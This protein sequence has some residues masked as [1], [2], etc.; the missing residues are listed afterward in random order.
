M[1]RG[2]LNPITKE[3][4]CSYNN[5][6]CN[7][8]Y[9][10]LYKNKKRN[11]IDKNNIIAQKNYKN[12]G[13][14]NKNNII[15]SRKKFRSRKKRS[16][17]KKYSKYQLKKDL[18]KLSNY[19]QRHLNPNLVKETPTTPPTIDEL[20]ILDEST[21]TKADQPNEIPSSK[22]EDLNKGSSC[23]ITNPKP[24]PT[25]TKDDA[26]TITPKRDIPNNDSRRSLFNSTTH[27]CDVQKAHHKN[28]VSPKIDVVRSKIY[29]DIQHSIIDGSHGVKQQLKK[30]IRSYGDRCELFTIPE[31]QTI[32]KVPITITK[33]YG[34]L[35]KRVIRK[36]KKAL[37]KFIFRYTTG[38]G[39][40]IRHQGKKYGRNHIKRKFRR[41]YDIKHITKTI[42]TSC[43][44]GSLAIKCKFKNIINELDESYKKLKNNILEST[45]DLNLAVNK[46]NK[47]LCGK[48]ILCIPELGEGLEIVDDFDSTE[49]EYSSEFKGE[50]LGTSGNDECHITSSL[51]GIT[52]DLNLKNSVARFITSELGAVTALADTGASLCLLSDRL[53]NDPVIKKSIL[54]ERKPRK[55]NGA[56]D[57]TFDISEYILLGFK[58][59]DGNIIHERFYFT[60][61]N[62]HN[63]II[64]RN[65][66]RRL[67]YRLCIPSV[68]FTH[69]GDKERFEVDPESPFLEGIDYFNYHE[70]ELYHVSFA[71]LKL[72]NKKYQH[73][74]ENI[75]NKYENIH[76]RGRTDV[77]IIPDFEFEIKLKPGARPHCSGVYPQSRA[78]EAEISQQVSEL[79]EAGLIEHSNAEW[80]AGTFVVPKPHSKWRMV[81]DYRE[82]NRWTVKDAYPMKDMQQLVK[83]FKGARYF[84]AIDLRSGYYHMRVKESSRDYLSFRT[85]QG[86]Y[87]WKVVPFGPTNAPAQFQRIMDKVLKDLSFAVAFLDDIII[88]SET[89]EEHIKHIEAVISRLSKFNLKI[90]LPKCSFFASEVLYLGHRINRHGVQADATA[91]KNILDFKKPSNPKEIERFIGLVNWIAG[92]ISNASSIL[93]PL[94]RLKSCKNKWQWTQNEEAAYQQILK[95][96]QQNNILSFPDFSKPFIL[97]TDASG[98]GL[99]AVLLQE[100]GGKVRPIQFASKKLSKEQVLWHAAEK[101]V[102]AVVWA[103]EKWRSYLIPHHNTIYTDARNLVS[104]FEKS[105]DHKNR[106]WRWALRV[107][108]FT[109]T[110][111]YK[112]G[113]LNVVAD[114]FSRDHPILH[115][116]SCTGSDPTK[117]CFSKR[118]VIG[119]EQNVIE[120]TQLH[121]A[122]EALY[123]YPTYLESRSSKNDKDIPSLDKK[124]HYTLSNSFR[125]NTGGINGS[126][127]CSVS[128][129]PSKTGNKY[130]FNFV[131]DKNKFS[132]KNENLK[133][134]KNLN[135]IIRRRGKEPVPESSYLHQLLKVYDVNV[136]EDIH[137]NE[138][139][140]LKNNYK[141]HNN[142]FNQF[143]INPTEDSIKNNEIFFLDESDSNDI[144]V[145]DGFQLPKCPSC[146]SELVS[147]VFRSGGSRRRKIEERHCDECQKD[148]INGQQY[149]RC[150]VHDYDLCLSCG[151]RD[152]DINDNTNHDPNTLNEKEIIDVDKD[153]Y[154]IKGNKYFQDI[155]VTTN[156][157]SHEI[158]LSDVIKAQEKDPN[159]AIIKK[160][161]LNKDDIVVKTHLPFIRKSYQ[162]GF[163]K[164]HFRLVDNVIIYI[165]PRLKQHAR[166]EL[167]KSLRAYI[168]QHY[169]Q[170]YIHNSRDKIINELKNKLHWYGM[171]MDIEEYLKNCETCQFSSK[172][173]L[174]KKVGKLKLF[175]ARKFNEF[176]SCDLVGPLPVTSSGN[177][178]LLTMMDRFSRY[179]KV[180]PIP[181]ISTFTVAKG[182]LN[183]WIYELGCF[184]KLLSDQGSQFKSDLFKVLTGMIG[185][186]KIFSSTYHPE[187][188]GMIERLHRW[189]KERLG[190]MVVEF[191][192][193]F[194]RS[195][196]DWDDYVKVIEFHH[197]HSIHK[198]TGFAPFTLATGREPF[199]PLALSLNIKN[200][201]KL[202]KEED[203][204]LY[205]ERL[206]KLLSQDICVANKNQDKYDK[207]R[208][209]YFDKHHSNKSFKIGDKVLLSIAERYQGNK[210]KLSKIYDGPFRV[211][212]TINEVSYK[213]L[214][215]TASDEEP[216]PTKEPTIVAHVSKLKLYKVTDLDEYIIPN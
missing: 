125:C 185:F 68:R 189:L 213:L 12:C 17:K 198:A 195:K 86:L 162:I 95:I 19:I 128:L 76:S 87:R 9:L 1:V 174:R 65:L 134:L 164:N 40:K 160:L 130:I 91:I 138:L 143:S 80:A 151:G 34:K 190:T 92:F 145:H 199:D 188:N 102:F 157:F 113:P 7:Y 103:L 147:D 202:L 43:K 204:Q 84:S 22:I 56:N 112:P 207:H 78:A 26:D 211:I 178:Y 23:S 29:A 4:N 108:P 31:T 89:E 139:N 63:F 114:Y 177:R 47:I 127:H 131:N 16:R 146:K 173:K 166:I 100:Q 74:L 135:N 165:D 73:K 141:L 18:N 176:V 191:N 206:S 54:T 110:A 163:K 216:D 38:D 62:K 172:S 46:A 79:L 133:N 119:S 153:T 144:L 15:N 8:K 33:W 97:E 3:N 53:K 205:F 136:Y 203:H 105:R 24:K 93:A 69:I 55:V 167:P 104:L 21:P 168:I 66:L 140:E 14:I 106:L 212:G 28:V 180:I 118:L 75:L 149:F 121:H 111:I 11:N 60:K 96:V 184:D 107:S 171:K 77:G 214:R 25:G 71:D 193:D 44:F 187:C 183:Y 182:I 152:E 35:Q 51:D 5:N 186:K 169:H 6:L 109:F 94:S 115:D 156:T 42:K 116:D 85:R 196:D 99:G 45:N 123:Y 64:G 36:A 101:E 88:F 181:D 67:G 13:G 2:N 122:V 150:N 170:H 158:S 148:F 41:I 90:N 154:I 129:D 161:L 61:S 32:N 132:S 179:A 70:E 200:K 155:H 194:I 83:L 59:Y 208:K 120:E 39:I 197:N 49:D 20:F 201:Y 30:E 117:Y 48:D 72:Y 124:L 52:G 82:L 98:I 142:F 57:T 10:K 81:C 37:N 215:I 126:S 58:K 50:V 209:L 27:S 175:P 192:L 137:T 210:R 159:L